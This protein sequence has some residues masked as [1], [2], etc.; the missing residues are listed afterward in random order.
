LPPGIIQSTSRAQGRDNVLPC[1]PPAQ[2]KVAYEAN[3]DKIIE[4]LKKAGGDIIRLQNELAIGPNRSQVLTDILDVL[5]QPGNEKIKTEFER[6]CRLNQNALS[7]TSQQSFLKELAGETS[8][9]ENN[10]HRMNIMAR[11]WLQSNGKSN[12]NAPSN[13]ALEAEAIALE[14]KEKIKEQ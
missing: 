4:D 7:R 1:R 6:L 8:W 12:N 14:L 5:E 2:I 10:P 13:D 9:S 3:P 11:V